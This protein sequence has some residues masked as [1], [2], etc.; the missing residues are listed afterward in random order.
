MDCNYPLFY[1]GLRGLTN[2]EVIDA[3]YKQL[4]EYCDI[5]E[6]DVPQATADYKEK[7]RLVFDRAARGNPG[8]SFVS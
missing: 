2:Q 6:E 7:L 3:I 1:T 5:P 8:N 4:R